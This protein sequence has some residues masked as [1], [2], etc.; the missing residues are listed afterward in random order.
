VGDNALVVM[1]LTEETLRMNP[2]FDLA[3]GVDLGGTKTEAVVLRVD[4][5]EELSRVRVP[6]LREEG[7]DA[8]VAR[9]ADT[10]RAAVRDAGTGLERATLGVGMPGSITRLGGL[11]KNSNTTCLNGRP[12]REDLARA[13]GHPIVFENDANCFALAEAL[14]GAARSHA[15]G[16]VFGVIMGTGVG[17]GL[18]VKGEVWEGAHGIGGEWGHHAVWAGRPDAR[19]CYC[20]QKGCVEV[21]ASG[22]AVEADYAARSGRRLTAR[23][24]AAQRDDDSHAHAAI[25]TLLDTFGR[26]LANLIDVLDPTAIVLGGGLSNLDLLLDEG[27]SRVARYVFNDEL[28]TPILR[29]ELGDSAGVFGAALRGWASRQR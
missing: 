21:Y 17:G 8:V 3:V 18:V 22:T 15:H 1:F 4:P 9:T 28:L 12:F 25:D 19:A 2:P 24:I 29:N 14:R 20:G 16:I 10:V 26:A 6:T 7:Y 13:L 23:E 5:F 11:V 27:R